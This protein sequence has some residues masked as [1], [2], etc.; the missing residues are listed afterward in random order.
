LGV[1]T[2]FIKPGS[3]W[4]NGYI[5]WFD[6]KKRDRLLN[7]ANV[8]TPE[9]VES[10]GRAMDAK[11]SSD[12]TAPSQEVPARSALIDFDRGIHLKPDMTLGCRL[13]FISNMT[14]PRLFFGLFSPE[15]LS[16]LRRHR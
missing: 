8:I 14:D 9:E 10:L 15:K 7:Q 2:L 12:I 11:T 6:G 3:L 5:Q 13:R 1:K 16:A 4:A